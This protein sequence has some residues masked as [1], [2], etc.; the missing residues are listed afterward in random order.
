MTGVPVT[1]VPS[2][3]SKYE[4]IHLMEDCKLDPQAQAPESKDD[5][6]PTARHV[7]LTETGHSPRA[8]MQLYKIVKLNL[9]HP[10]HAFSTSEIASIYLG[11]AKTKR[12]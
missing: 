4:T 1:S 2:S 8:T 11:S 12:T 6:S 3:N 9:S 10:S 5:L 7:H